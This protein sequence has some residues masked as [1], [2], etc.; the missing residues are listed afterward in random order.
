M[1]IYD[2][3]QSLSNI[4]AGSVLSIGNFDGLHL[5]HQEIIKTAAS[6]AHKHDV[7]LAAMTFEPHPA[8]ILNPQKAPGTLTPLPLKTYLF[9]KFGID[10]L[11]IIKD[12]YELLNLSP[13]DF[14][15]KF[16][17]ANIAPAVVV[18]GPN[19]N[20]GYGRSGNIQTLK[21]LAAE[22]NFAVIEVKPKKINLPQ[23]NRTICSSSLIRELL[24]TGRVADAK[25]AMSRPYRL[26]GPTVPGRGVG[27][28]IGFPTA[29][30]EPTD[31]IIPAEGVYAGLVYTGNSIE[32]VCGSSSPRPAAFSIGRAK[33][34]ITDHPILTEAHILE[35]DVGDLTGKWLAMDFIKKIRSQKRFE[36][37]NDL[38]QQIAKDC[39]AAKEILKSI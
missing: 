23:I 15:D 35:P 13:Q 5:G 33:T 9:E 10:C 25:T 34:F 6:E 11:I 19:F 32:D 37:H 1:Q 31:Q 7:P 38:K 26:I 28:Q 24:N 18:E 2:S 3:I 17:I 30:I 16:L 36:N 14:V 20:F 12:N 21:Q 8:A 39:Q 22:R 29:N 4:P 27:A